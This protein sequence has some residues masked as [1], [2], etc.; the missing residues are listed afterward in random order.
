MKEVYVIEPIVEKLV[1]VDESDEDTVS[2][3]MIAVIVI[4]RVSLRS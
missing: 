3:F 4:L 2:T 1:K